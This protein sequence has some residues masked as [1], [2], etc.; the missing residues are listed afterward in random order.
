MPKQTE[1]LVHVDEA[2]RTRDLAR[3]AGQNNPVLSFP[4]SGD[5][6]RVHAAARRPRW[7]STTQDWPDRRVGRFFPR[8]ARSGPAGNGRASKES[9]LCHRHRWR[10]DVGRTR[11]SRADGVRLVATAHPGSCPACS[12]SRR[13]AELDPGG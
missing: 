13:R 8:W 1:S 6:V 5:R 3:A 7:V 10:S 12:S 2:L 9:W 4:E 11:I